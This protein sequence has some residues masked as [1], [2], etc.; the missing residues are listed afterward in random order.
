MRIGYAN[1]F[2]SDLGTSIRFFRDTL[3]LSLEVGDEAIAGTSPLKAVY[4]SAH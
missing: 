1:V 2:V 4:R 3:G